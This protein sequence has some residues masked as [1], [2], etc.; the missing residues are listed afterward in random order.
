MKR[1]IFVTGAASGIGKAVAAR[2][3]AEGFFVGLYDVNEAGLDAM[4]ATLGPERCCSGKLDV[5]DL[6]A[7]RRAVAAFGSATGERMDVLFN[8]AGIL[9]FGHFEKVTPEEARLQISVNCEGVLNGIYAS[10]PMLEKTAA[11]AG[12]SRGE[13]PIIVSMSSAAAIYG[14]P[15]LAAYSAT[16]FFVRGLTE[17]LDLEFRAKNIRVADVMPGFVDTPMVHSQT[18]RPKAQDL[19]GVK[20]TADD[21]AQVVWNAVHGDKVHWPTKLEL[22]ILVRL[23]GL[24]ELA[25]TVMRR[26]LT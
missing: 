16:K 11:A 21:V 6:D 26:F 23:S 3:A 2:F 9:R 13:K 14:Q 1:T 10:L 20:T 17:A 5:G 15:E 18:H 24:T 22:G 7:Y 8:C 12:K 25:R 4:R 19:L